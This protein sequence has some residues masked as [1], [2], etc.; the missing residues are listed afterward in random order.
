MVAID[1]GDRLQELFHRA[2]TLAR[3]GTRLFAAVPF[4]DPASRLWKLLHLATDKGVAVRL[5]TRQP[6]EPDKLAALC[7]LEDSGAKVVFVPNLHAKAFIWIGHVREDVIGY[8]G[9][10]NLTISSEDRSFEVGIAF[11]G[12]GPVEAILLRDLFV[13]FDR[14]ERSVRGRVQTTTAQSWGLLA[15]RRLL[16]I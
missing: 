8:V 16:S 1:R 5:L 10:H 4:F 14:W 7:S 11:R 13:A 2:A 6:P 9:S 15:A 3:T 12:R